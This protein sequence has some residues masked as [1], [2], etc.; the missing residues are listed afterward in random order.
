MRAG[1]EIIMLSHH[2]GFDVFHLLVADRPSR[3][4]KIRHSR[5]L[6]V[7]DSFTLSTGEKF[8]IV[9]LTTRRIWAVSCKT[10]GK[11]EK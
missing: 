4:L 10:K 3:L 6:G 2:P 1:A 11:G 8:E 9:K 5:E 7:G